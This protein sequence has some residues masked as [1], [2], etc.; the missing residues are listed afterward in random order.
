MVLLVEDQ[1]SVRA[2]V[3]RVLEARGHRVL[4]AAGGPEALQLAAAHAGPIDLLLTDVVMPQMNGLELAQ[5]LTA[6]RTGLCVLFMSGYAEEEIASR[7][8]L[9]PPMHLIEKPFEPAELARRVREVLNA[10]L[11]T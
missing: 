8:R 4:E 1:P 10:A 6:V 5:R 2:L 9:D 11:H 7:G 3:R